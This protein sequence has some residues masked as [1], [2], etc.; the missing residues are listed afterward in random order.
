MSNKRSVLVTGATGQQGGAAADALLRR[1]HEVI[2]L[3]RNPDSQRA[4]DLV[5]RGASLAVGDFSDPDSLVRAARGTDAAYAMMTPFEAGIE[6]EIAQGLALIEALKAAGVGHLVLGSVA[7]ADQATGIPHFDSKY[8]VEK[9]LASL[10]L[11]YSIVAPVYFMDNLLAPWSLPALKAGKLA[12]ALPADRPLQQV[13]VRDIGAF[14]AAL[15]ER[16]EAVFGQRFDIA[17]DELT[18]SEAAAIVAAASGREIGFESFPPE[19]LRAESEDLALMFEWFD[20]VGYSADIEALR[21]DFPEV[22]WL[23]F[24]DWAGQQDWRVL[25]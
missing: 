1:G 10:G 3:T 2:A 17:G 7:N 13:A 8:E 25:G 5:E 18:G 4:R 15:I 14:A 9:H 12:M 21:R 22:P 16:R 11:A 23:S 6:A 20:R 19:V 24:A